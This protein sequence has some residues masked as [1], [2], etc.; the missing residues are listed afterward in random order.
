M[1]PPMRSRR[2]WRTAALATVICGLGCASAPAPAPSEPAASPRPKPASPSRPVSS[3]PAAAVATA[4]P[5][6][7]PASS[8]AAPGLGLAREREPVGEPAPTIRDPRLLA[9]LARLERY[10]EPALSRNSGRLSAGCACCPPLLRPGC[11]SVVRRPTARSVPG[12]MGSRVIRPLNPVATRSSLNSALPPG[13]TTASC[14]VRNCA[15]S[16]A[17]SNSRALRKRRSGS[18]GCP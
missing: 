11:K 7:L 4:P 3:A 15:L 14:L 8:P 10:C 17:R 1:L 6:P 2:V 18:F 12:G 9:S 13:N 16:S 5:A